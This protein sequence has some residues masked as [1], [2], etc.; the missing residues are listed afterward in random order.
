MVYWNSLVLCSCCCGRMFFILCPR[1]GNGIPN[2]RIKLLPITSNGWTDDRKQN[3]PRL[4][5]DHSGTVSSYIYSHSAGCGYSRDET[6]SG[7]IAHAIHYVVLPLHCLL[8]CTKTELGANRSIT[9]WVHVFLS[10]SGSP[11]RIYCLYFMCYKKAENKRFSV[12]GVSTCR[13]EGGS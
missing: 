9:S 7:L 3:K 13:V 11:F 1:N 4:R 10:F 8:L 5:N 6:M 2:L 12:T